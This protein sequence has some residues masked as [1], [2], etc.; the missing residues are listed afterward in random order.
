MSFLS[1]CV[2]KSLLKQ[3]KAN[4]TVEQII[5]ST[6]YNDESAL[7]SKEEEKGTSMDAGLLED[8]KNE[9]SHYQI[10]MDT[11]SDMLSEIEQELD[12]Y[13]SAISTNIKSDCKLNFS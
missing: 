7:V 8:Y 6:Y 3:E 11:C 10:E 1:L 2:E 12:S 5:A 13:N 4:Y 9:E